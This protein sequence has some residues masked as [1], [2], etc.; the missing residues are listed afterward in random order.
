MN[1]TLCNYIFIKT[2]IITYTY[3]GMYTEL[4]PKVPLASSPHPLTMSLTTYR[5][6]GRERFP[7]PLRKVTYI[8][9]R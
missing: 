3:V 2:G 9:T 1:V 5:D 6:D 7:P 8:S 4:T